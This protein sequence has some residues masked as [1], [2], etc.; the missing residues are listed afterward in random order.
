MLGTIDPGVTRS[1]R[2]NLDLGVER[3]GAV[4]RGRVAAAAVVVI[5]LGFAVAASA[6]AEPL[7]ATAFPKTCPSASIVSSALG[8]KAAAPVVTHSTYFTM[9]VYGSNALAPKVTFQ[10]DTA[11]TFAAGEKAAAAALP[12]A[13]ISHLGKAAWAPK[14][15]GS[16]YVFTGSY[17][18]KMLSPLTSLT[19]L[20][21]LA[22]K[23][24]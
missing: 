24:L 1:I 16:L 19:K 9:C 21:A 22:H 20:K 5:A 23:L 11:G 15:G 18:I 17:T 2:P 6:Q 13:K 7:R 3:S 8:G 10:Q 4:G 12:V 14:S